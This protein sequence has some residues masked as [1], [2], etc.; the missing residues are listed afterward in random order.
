MRVLRE[1]LRNDRR[2]L[3]RRHLSCKLVLALAERTELRFQGVTL[4]W[5][6]WVRDVKPNEAC[7]AC[8]ATAN[9]L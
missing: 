9:F 4:R 2:Q 3:V 7:E 6:D 8:E 5:F 1:E